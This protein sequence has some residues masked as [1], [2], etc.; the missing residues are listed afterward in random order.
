M[1][2]GRPKPEIRLIFWL[3][4]AIPS[5]DQDYH[6]L[7][8]DELEDDDHEDDEKH[9]D[10]YDDD[11]GCLGGGWLT[12]LEKK[13]LK[14]GRL[15]LS[16]I[17]YGFNHHDKDEDDEDDGTVYDLRYSGSDH[18]DDDDDTVYYDEDTK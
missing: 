7:N 17:F 15:S 12:V 3:I 4:I 14:R 11:D 13:D 6:N 5:D 10:E 8:R 16:G 18:D 2:G 1:E 9:D